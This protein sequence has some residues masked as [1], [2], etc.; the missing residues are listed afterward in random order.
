MNLRGVKATSVILDDFEPMG[1]R[2]STFTQDSKFLID[3]IPYHYANP[4]MYSFAELEEMANWCRHTFG[5]PGYNQD[6]MRTVWNY[7][8]DP[9]YLF[10]FSDEKNLMLLILRWS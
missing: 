4:I 1:R 8:S 6:N 9:D 5:N 10:W 3:K 2:I 7:R